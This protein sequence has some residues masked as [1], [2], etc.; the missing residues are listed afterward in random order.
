M[1]L[2]YFQEMMVMCSIYTCLFI[3][4]NTTCLLLST[5]ILQMMI[6]LCGRTL[7]LLF[8][9][10]FSL[11]IPLEGRLLLVWL[12]ILLWH[13]RSCTAPSMIHT[14]MSEEKEGEGCCCTAFLHLI[15]H[16]M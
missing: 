5:V 12:T 3:N 2:R 15:C 8:L 4:G 9:P 7:P 1:F 16:P 13:G 10:T 11:V 14:T 6:L